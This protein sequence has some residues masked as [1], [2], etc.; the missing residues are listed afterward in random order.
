MAGVAFDTFTYLI[1]GLLSQLPYWLAAIIFVLNHLPRTRKSNSLLFYCIYT[2]GIVTGA[3][4]GIG[5]AYVFLADSNTTSPYWIT[6]M[7]FMMGHIAALS[8]WPITIWRERVS[9]RRP[10]TGVSTTVLAPINSLRAIIFVGSALVFLIIEWG[11]IGMLTPP[12]ANL[13]NWV[14]FYLYIPYVT[15]V[16]GTFIALSCY[17]WKWTWSYFSV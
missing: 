6:A 2:L 5:R 11:M 1:I 12:N 13:V 15:I 17:Y 9:Y 14:S 10:E 3:V 16:L 8:L 4:V 7:T